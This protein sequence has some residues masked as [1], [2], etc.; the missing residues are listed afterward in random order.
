[1]EIVVRHIKSQG[2]IIVA[3]TSVAVSAGKT[4][5]SSKEDAII[6]AQRRYPNAQIKHEG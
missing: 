6:E 4:V 3:Q 5:Y 2:W 1:M